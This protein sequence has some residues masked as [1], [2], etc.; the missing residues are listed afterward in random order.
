MPGDWELIEAGR[1]RNVV[2]Q[3]ECGN[4]VWQDESVGSGQEGSGRTL[5]LNC[6]IGR[7][8]RLQLVKVV[9]E[10]R[11]GNGKKTGSETVSPT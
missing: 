6:R 7:T 11:K 4:G 2:W 8:E 1:R 5:G 10:K 9:Q 3:P